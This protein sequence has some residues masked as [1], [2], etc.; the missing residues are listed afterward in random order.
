MKVAQYYTD[1]HGKRFEVISVWTPDD[2]SSTMVRY[3]NNATGDDYTC[4]L[5]AFL[6]RFFETPA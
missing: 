3:V 6:S 5:E 1:S 4:R 2:E